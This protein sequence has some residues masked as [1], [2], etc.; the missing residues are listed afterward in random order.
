MPDRIEHVACLGCGCGCDDITV[1]VSDGRI[2][3]L[4][5]AC[6]VGRAWFG[7]GLVPGE[8]LHSGQPATID[9]AIT[10]AA[11]LLTQAGRRSLLYLGADLTVQ[12]QRQTLA[13]AD[14]LGATV[15][16]ATSETS[17]GGLIAAQRQ[18]RAGATLGELRNRAD[19]LVFWGVDPVQRYPRFLTR[20]VD[21]E[22]TH[23][24][25]G[26]AG[27]TIIG[28]SV[29]KDRAPGSADLALD[30]MPA[31]E[32]SALSYL[33]HALQSS[34]TRVSSPRAGELDALAA[35]LAGA[36]YV[37]LIHDAEPTAEPRNP[38]RAEALIALTQALNGPTRAALVS[39]RAGGNRVGAESVL[40]WQTGYPLSV[41]YSRG[42][43]RYLP[44][45]R[46]L[47]RLRTGAYR[48]VLLAGSADPDDLR[49][50]LAGAADVVIIGPRA[51][52]SSLRPRIAIDTGVAGIHEAGTAY[53][54]DEVPLRL[55][56]PL[57]GL[58]STTEVLHALTQAI[59]H[60]LAERGS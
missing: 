24:P 4:H 1:T 55:R 10:G 5:P 32:E 21:A 40:T 28:I 8:V 36:R 51:S 29:G 39:L 6:P 37:V 23:M 19:V 54:L 45:R 42:A 26:R 12:A 15:D 48:A 13:L 27:R 43:P 49:S 52:R 2:T 46:G 41:D 16:T 35:R 34:A 31:E 11:L 17:A 57:P 3:E 20:Y 47:S 7:D 9:E 56:P 33:R 44:G 30:L 25:R 18:G 53:R 50:P 14:L 22:G 58:R 59:Q 60:T 38:L